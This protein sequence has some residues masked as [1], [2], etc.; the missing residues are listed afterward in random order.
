MSI[1]VKIDSMPHFE[2][3]SLIWRGGHETQGR[4]ELQRPLPWPVKNVRLAFGEGGRDPSRRAPC[5]PGIVRLGGRGTPSP[6]ASRHPS[7]HQGTPCPN[8]PQCFTV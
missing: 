2:G 6:R 4:Q 7:R 8:I 5:L 1:C 3:M